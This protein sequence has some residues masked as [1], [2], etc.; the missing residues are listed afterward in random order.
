MF[1]PMLRPLF[2][3]FVLCMTTLPGC[4]PAGP[5]T[6]SEPSAS[7]SPAA[8]SSASSLPQT[9]P[10]VQTT[11]QV[12]SPFQ[13]AYGETV[14]FKQLHIRFSKV[15]SDSRCPNGVQCIWA[16]EVSVELELSENNQTETVA[17]TLAR[18]STEKSVLNGKYRLSLLAVTPQP[19]EGQELASKA[20]HLRL[21]L[22]LPTEQ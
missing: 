21:L 18:D 1:H 10:Q 16:G 11:V 17:L 7:S 12:G 19:Q 3:A 13:L 22:N 6:H 5:E 8:V 9:Q 20:Y 4:Q 14:S 15:L 2:T